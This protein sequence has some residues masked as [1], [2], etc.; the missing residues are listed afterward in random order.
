M[1]SRR[2]YEVKRYELES[3]YEDLR[4]LAQELHVPIWTASQTNRAA[5]DEEIITLS[6]I[7]EA[8]AKAQVSDF[9]ISLS[10]KMAD[11]LNNTGRFYLAKNRNGVDG[12][13]IPLYVNT[14]TGTIKLQGDTDDNQAR[15][16]YGAHNAVEDEQASNEQLKERL[17]AIK[18]G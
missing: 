10:R 18:E 13:V 5:I 9:I 6:S 4:A 3:I 7:A 15:S 2:R 1:K 8:Y 11:K 12:I 14:V 17:K 16:P